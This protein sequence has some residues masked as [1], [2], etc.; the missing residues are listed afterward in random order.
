MCGAAVQVMY[1]CTVSKDPLGA[2]RL[3]KAVHRNSLLLLLVELGTGFD[4]PLNVYCSCTIVMAR[5]LVTGSR[6]LTVMEGES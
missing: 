3:C 6:V 1:S 4:G 2:V 5:T